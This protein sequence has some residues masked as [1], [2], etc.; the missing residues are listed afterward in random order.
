MRFKG[1]ISENAS[2]FLQKNLQSNQ[3]W[4]MRLK[5]ETKEQFVAI[6]DNFTDFSGHR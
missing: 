3:V 5:Y 6:G 4:R 1:N 2:S